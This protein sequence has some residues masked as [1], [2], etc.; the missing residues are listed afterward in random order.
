MAS[1]GAAHELSI[2]LQLARCTEETS[3]KLWG[4]ASSFTIA[5]GKFSRV[6]QRLKKATDRRGVLQNDELTAACICCKKSLQ[7][8]HDFLM[9]ISKLK[10]MESRILH[11]TGPISLSDR[12]RNILTKIEQKLTEHA[13]RISFFT[14]YESAVASKTLADSLDAVSGGS[15]ALKIVANRITSRLMVSRESLFI[16]E[17]RSSGPNALWEAVLDKF[18]AEGFSLDFL[19]QRKKDILAYVQGLEKSSRPEALGSRP[20]SGIQN[21]GTPA[22]H[23]TRTPTNISMSEKLFD[24]GPPVASNKSPVVDNPFTAPEAI[25]NNPSSPGEPFILN[26]SA[27]D[28]NTQ[29]H[30]MPSSRKRLRS[31]GN[32]ATSSVPNYRD[33]RYTKFGRQDIVYGTT[34]DDETILADLLSGSQSHHFASTRDRIREIYQS[35]TNVYSPRCE[36]LLPQSGMKRNR[37]LQHLKGE[38]ELLVLGGL[39]QMY[40][41]MDE[42]LYKLRM[43]IVVKVQALLKKIDE[44][45]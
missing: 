27:N 16:A 45:G 12:Q 37:E 14:I 40:L 19:D 44:A 34:I 2:L 13:Y 23:G 8:S 31:T 10:D 15:R 35:F 43:A 36:I 22:Q 28:Q 17:T 20:A 7:D 33:T 24:D 32:E 5:T 39:N 30:S 21:H 1:N 38:I 18:K 3:Q 4:H 11:S 41:D 6:L 25:S 9:A 26:F 29:P 42:E